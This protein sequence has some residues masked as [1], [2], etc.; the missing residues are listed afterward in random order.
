MVDVISYTEITGDIVV[1]GDL[2]AENLI[3]GSTNIITEINTKQDTIQD[4][5]LQISNTLNL[6]TTLTNLDTNITENTSDITTLNK[7]NLIYNSKS[8]IDKAVS[9]WNDRTILT[10]NWKKIIWVAELNLFIGI[11]ISTSGNRMMTSSNGIDW[12]V[13][14]N[15]PSIAL[16]DIVWSA[17]L[18]L[19][20]VVATSSLNT[21]PAIYTSSNGIN[22]TPQPP[23]QLTTTGS[24]WCSNSHSYG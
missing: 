1:A 8:Y 20:V 5:D 9:T 23:P 6:Q 13:V 16:Q 2:T 10:G 18:S 12:E 3:V 21:T 22:W 14:V 24:V 11:S 7:N 19:L 17:E 15:S 4:G